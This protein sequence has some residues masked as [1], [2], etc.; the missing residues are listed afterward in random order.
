MDWLNQ[1]SSFL[2]NPTVSQIAGNL[3][4]NNKPKPAPTPAPVI[5]QAPAPEI[6]KASMSASKIALIG[7]GVLAVVL[8]LVFALK[9]K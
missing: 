8:V 2:S 9:R 5:I 4:G 3:L 1:A 7:G 6:P